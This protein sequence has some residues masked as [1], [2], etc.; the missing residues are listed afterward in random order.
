MS[1]V[2]VQSALSE[3][4]ISNVLGSMRKVVIYGSSAPCEGSSEYT[5]AQELGSKLSAAGFG[6]VTGGY[7]GTME[8]VSRG[9]KE[10]GCEHVCGRGCRT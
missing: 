10:N 9:A 4:Y 2:S 3:S 6:V 7:S 5:Q 8:A 1:N